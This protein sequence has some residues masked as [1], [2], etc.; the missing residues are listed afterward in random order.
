MME[1][2]LIESLIFAV[3]LIIRAVICRRSGSG[4]EHRLGMKSFRSHPVFRI[5][6][7]SDGPDGLWTDSGLE[8]P[9]GPDSPD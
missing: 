2:N 4:N 8:G 7:R 9:L 3:C 1:P 6:R 5:T